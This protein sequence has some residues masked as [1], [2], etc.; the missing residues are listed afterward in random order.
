MHDLDNRSSRW[1]RH[2][3]TTPG[4]LY[5]SCSAGFLDIADWLLT[6]GAE[7]N[8]QGGN[9]GNALYTA[10]YNSHEAIVQLLLDQGVEVNA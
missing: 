7:P 1:H 10:S 6:E 2:A 3:K 9:Y 8:A 4:P 5:Y